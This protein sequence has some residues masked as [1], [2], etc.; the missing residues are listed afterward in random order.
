MKASTSRLEKLKKN[1]QEIQVI[2][3]CSLVEI[4]KYQ[5]WMSN[6]FPCHQ[7]KPQLFHLWFSLQMNQVLRTLLP[8]WETENKF[9]APYFHQV[10]PQLLQPFKRINQTEEFH[11]PPIPWSSNFQIINKYLNKQKDHGK[12]NSKHITGSTPERQK[13]SYNTGT[14][15]WMCA[16]NWGI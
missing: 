14:Y 5:N 7:Y 10:Q 4:I 12:C 2:V 11:L 8:M 13:L 15:W 3:W 16:T 6:L 1:Y 9:L